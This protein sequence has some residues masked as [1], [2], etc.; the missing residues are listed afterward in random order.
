MYD[1]KAEQ[2]KIIHAMQENMFAH[3]LFFPEQ[4]PSFAVLK[5]QG[6]TL[7]DSGLANDSFNLVFNAR[8]KQNAFDIV[9]STVDHF[10]RESLPFSWWVSPDDFPIELPELLAHAG[11][12]LAQKN[13][14]MYLSIEDHAY[15][16]GILRI[17]RVL[18]ETCMQDFTEVALDYMGHTP[19]AKAY[20][21][22][23]S[24]FPFSQDDCE[25]LYVGYLDEEPV[26]IGILTLHSKVAGIH[27]LITR[28]Q[29]RRRGF[30]TAMVQELLMRAQ[31]AEYAIAVL[32][33]HK[34]AINLYAHIGFEP[35]CEFY[36]YT[37]N[38]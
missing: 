29:Q 17:E 36:E 22:Q 12:K 9:E 26:T 14:G 16:Q 1:T 4:L 11:L 7:V 6:L 8:L 31:I 20:Y 19:A 3:M 24:L 28:E 32:Q 27:S 37:L 23:L 30:G 34:D 5:A 2:Q 15:E 21:D 25:Q 38:Q 10:K 18:D 35:L 13:I 33:A